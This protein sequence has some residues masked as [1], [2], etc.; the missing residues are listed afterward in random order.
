LRG[1]ERYLSAVLLLH[2]VSSE[3]RLNDDVFHFSAVV[4]LLFPSLIPTSTEA[5]CNNARYYI[6]VR[7]CYFPVLLF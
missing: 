2:P 5:P 7:Q 3:E 6:L 4:S 1:F